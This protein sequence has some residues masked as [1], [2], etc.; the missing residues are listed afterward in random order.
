VLGATA[1][2]RGQR[3]ERAPGGAWFD[4]LLRRKPG[5]VAAVALANKMARVVWAVLTKGGGYRPLGGS[6]PEGNGI[7]AA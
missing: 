7:A 1:Q 4:A 5:R 2:I 3:R 6:M